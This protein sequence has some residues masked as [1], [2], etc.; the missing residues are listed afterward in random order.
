MHFWTSLSVRS[1]KHEVLYLIK[2]W[3]K[4]PVFHI[5]YCA[6]T[7]ITGF[8]LPEAEHISDVSFSP[9]VTPQYVKS[10][11]KTRDGQILFSR[12]KNWY[13]VMTQL[14]SY[15]AASVHLIGTLTCIP[16]LRRPITGNWTC[17]CWGF[18]LKCL[19][20][21]VVEDLYRCRV[22][23]VRSTATDSSNSCGW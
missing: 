5:L 4:S 22:R 11:A 8:Y 14:R 17:N 9:C 19:P 6:I 15:D 20:Y 13:R 21:G 12:A 23:S 16:I 2:I 3:D 1:V 7:Q 18:L 10:L